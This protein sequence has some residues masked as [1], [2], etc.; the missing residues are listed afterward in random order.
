MAWVDYYKQ[1]EEQLAM[2]LAGTTEPGG[3]LPGVPVDVS[4][5]AGVAVAL[6]DTN[7]VRASLYGK[8]TNAGD[9][10]VLTHATRGLAVAPYGVATTMADGLSNSPTLPRE[11]N[12]LTL[13]WV[14]Y[15]TLFNGT[16]WDRRRGN[17]EV[18]V[19][20][21]AARTS[22]I[23]SAD[24]TN[25]NGR[26]VRVYVN[27]TAVAAT[28]SIVVTVEGKDPVSGVYTEILASAAI[29]GTGMTVLAVYPG[30]A[31]VANA[32]ANVALPR[33]WRVTATHADTDSITYSVGAS[34]IL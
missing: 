34:V 31:A 1:V 19:L 6:D 13:Y 3:A 16:T 10:P 25:H 17:V 29:T 11:I 2:L 27:V 21:S 9:T 20:A 24:Q 18:T 12:N 7:K 26:G 30:C 32:V 23:S 14:V 5:L 22:T 4:K 28:P 33:T 15:P 8:G